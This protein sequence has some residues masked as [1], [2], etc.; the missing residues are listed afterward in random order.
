MTYF[1]YEGFCP[2][3]ETETIYRADNDYYRNSLKCGNC[4]S[5]PRERG[6]AYMVRT[7]FPNWRA[8][9]IHECAPVM[10]GFSV[11]LNEECKNYIPMHYFP[12]F[13]LG[14][15]VQGYRNENVES[16]TFAEDAF[17]LVI[18]LDVMEHLFDPGKAYAEIWRT[19]KPGG[20]YIH[21]FPIHKTQVQAVADRAVLN[22]D[23][24]V[25]H[26]VEKPSYHGNPIDASGS[27][28]TKDYGYDISRKIAEYALFDVQISRFWD[29][30]HGILGEYTEVVICTKVLPG[31]NQLREAAM[32][33]IAHGDWQKAFE[34]LLEAH[35][36]RPAGPF[37]RLHLAR[38]LLE[39]GRAAEA[40]PHLEAIPDIPELEPLLSE[41]RARAKDELL[42]NSAASTST[43]DSLISRLK[44]LFAK[45][46]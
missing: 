22:Q 10:R 18:S 6:L 20:A 3:C 21:T 26:L 4:G 15:M 25:K 30:T 29:R 40:H 42:V 32:A 41:L 38:A 43:Q 39:L 8:L 9:S 37:I 2:V 46:L 11:K 1:S 31:A 44:K 14:T 24:S 33:A 23:G 35:R 5:I 28:V 19:L 7:L 17:D 36:L 13:D 34:S 12:D 27:L 16:Q 45:S